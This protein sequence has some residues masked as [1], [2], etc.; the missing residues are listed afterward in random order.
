MNHFK[1]SKYHN[2]EVHLLMNTGNILTGVALDII[3][4]NEKKRSTEYLFISSSD[5][6]V[7]KRLED[8]I[9]PEQRS[10]YEKVIDISN[11]ETAIYENADLEIRE[12]R[13]QIESNMY[14][15]ASFTGLMQSIFFL[16]EMNMAAPDYLL[17]EVH[18][19]MKSYAE[20]ELDI[21]PYNEK[22]REHALFKN[23]LLFILDNIESAIGARSNYPE[24]EQVFK[25]P[26]Y[27]ERLELETPVLEEPRPKYIPTDKKGNTINI[28]I[29]SPSDVDIREQLLN[30]L[31]TLFRRKGYEKTTGKRII[32]HGWEDLPPQNGKP[33]DII[34]ELLVKK[35]DIVVAIFNHT[36]GTPVIDDETGEKRSESG[37]A[38]E[39]IF[40]LDKEIDNKRRAPLG[41]AY[42]NEVAPYASFDNPDIDAL[43]KEWRRL[44]SFRKELSNKMLYKSY[45]KD[46]ELIDLICDGLH[47]NIENLFTN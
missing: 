35:V 31:E 37:T 2:R 18:M 9:R 3:D 41:M 7:W 30:S 21:S 32:V 25:K 12:I 17:H 8:S 33:Q 5:L 20:D 45:R 38:E 23:R 22:R 39:I 44:N 15:G 29:A 14:G 13:T 4:P 40:T 16:I 11:I 36:L 1:F 34:N 46:E 28:L 42:F 19:L 10:Q 43:L 27:G 24:P 26:E 6:K 47:K